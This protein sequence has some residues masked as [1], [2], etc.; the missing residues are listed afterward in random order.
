MESKDIIRRCMKA[1]GVTQE[2]LAKLMGY[3]SQSGVT[4]ILNRHKSMRVSNLVYML[5]ILGYE[6]I[7]ADKET[8]ERI[9]KVTDKYTKNTV[10]KPTKEPVAEVTEVRKKEIPV[11]Q[12]GK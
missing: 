11:F 1:K 9:G 3:S 8:G 2:E 10:K 5:N 7:V 12:Y 4:G 6:I